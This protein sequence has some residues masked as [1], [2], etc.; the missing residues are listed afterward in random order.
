MELQT[1]ELVRCTDISR[2]SLE[3]IAEHAATLEELSLDGL[4]TERAPFSEAGVP[5][6]LLV[7]GLQPLMVRG[8]CPWGCAPDICTFVIRF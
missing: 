4:C 1:L 8:V 5:K 6:A 2:A 7:G 3:A